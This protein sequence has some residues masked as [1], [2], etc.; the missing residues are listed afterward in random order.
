MSFTGRHAYLESLTMNNDALSVIHNM[1]LKIEMK[2][3]INFFLS[4][5]HRIKQ[6]KTTRKIFLVS[7]TITIHL[8][9]LH[10]IFISN[11]ILCYETMGT[12]SDNKHSFPRHFTW[13]LFNI[14]LY[15]ISYSSYYTSDNAKYNERF[16]PL[17]NS[18]Q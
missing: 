15:P 10:A 14:C 11:Y 6:N 17:S 4:L 13:Y 12:T 16:N 8:A 7:S 9:F 18:V 2:K 3:L 1:I 5:A